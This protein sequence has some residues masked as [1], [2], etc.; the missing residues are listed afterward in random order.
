M[1]YFVRFLVCILTMELV[2]HY[3]WVVAMKDTGSWQG[4]SPAEISMVGFW[5]LIIIWLKVCGAFQK[6]YHTVLTPFMTSSS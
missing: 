5:N 3:M 6:Q 1:Q 4:L 2:L